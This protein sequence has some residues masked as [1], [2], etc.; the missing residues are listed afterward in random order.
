[1]KIHIVQGGQ[2][3]PC[4]IYL[5][6]HINLDVQV[7]DIA[8]I[9]LESEYTVHLFSLK[10]T[11]L[12]PWASWDH[13]Y[14]G[15]GE[16]FLQVENG[17]LPMCIGGF[18]GG[19]EANSLVAV[20]ELNVEEGYERLHIV[21][22]TDLQVE[23]SL[24]GNLLFFQGLDVNL[25]HQAVVAHHLVP[26]HHIHQGFSEGNLPNGRHVEAINIVPPVDLVVLVLSVFV[27][28]A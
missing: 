1:M 26:V 18:W 13:L 25:L 3:N 5:E 15:T 9:W 7:A 11:K 23:G 20:G 21:V 2:N 10:K 17:L 6:I 28:S 16:V 19:G 24:K 14:L 4:F 8:V 12:K 27:S 22:A